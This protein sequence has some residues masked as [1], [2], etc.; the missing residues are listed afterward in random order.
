[1]SRTLV[2]S[3]GAA[4]VLVAVGLLGDAATVYSRDPLM[5]VGWIVSYAI[6]FHYIYCFTTKKD[7]YAG[8]ITVDS[9]GSKIIRLVL[10]LLG[11]SMVSWTMGSFYLGRNVLG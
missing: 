11:V 4:S 7:M 8:P 2:A 5:F 3:I 10:A 9:N 6:G 1:M